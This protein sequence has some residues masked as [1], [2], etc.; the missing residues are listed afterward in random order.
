MEVFYLAFLV[1][2][3]GAMIF[4]AAGYAS[5]HGYSLGAL[6]GC[7][8][9]M[10]FN[11]LAATLTASTQ[12]I[13]L[14]LGNGIN[15]NVNISSIGCGSSP[16]AVTTTQLRNQVSVN[17][18]GNTTLFVN[19][20]PTAGA[21]MSRGYQYKLFIVINYTVADASINQFRTSVG[22]FVGTAT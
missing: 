22:T 1:A 4:G 7:S 12:V 13:T 3:L 8:F 14:N 19:C 18:Y 20:T 15:S 6:P 5:L 16:S 21:R 10:D 2:L 11:C 9:N 17:L